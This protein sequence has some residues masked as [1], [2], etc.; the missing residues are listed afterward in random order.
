M[1]SVKSTSLLSS[2][3]PFEIELLFSCLKDQKLLTEV[4]RQLV[5]NTYTDSKALYKSVFRTDVYDDKKL[6]NTLFA[7]NKYIEQIIALR[8]IREEDTVRNFVL[9]RHCFQHNLTKEYN[10]Y[11]LKVMEQSRVAETSNLLFSYLS[12]KT[13]LDYVEEKKRQFI[14]DELIRKDQLLDA[15]YLKEKLW[16]LF[17]IDVYKNIYHFEYEPLLA[18]YISAIE[19]NK[20][21][22]AKN[23]VRFLQLLLKMMKDFDD[24][25][26]YYEALSVLEETHTHIPAKDLRLYYLA[27][28]NYA[29]KKFNTGKKEFRKEL[30]NVYTL[31]I[32]H[33]VLLNEKKTL[34]P[35]AYKNIITVA[36]QNGEFPWTKKFIDEYAAYLPKNE[37]ENAVQYNT[38]NYYYFVKNFKQCLQLLQTVQFTD[39]YYNLD[40]RCIILKIYFEEQ[41]WNLLYD[42]CFAFKAF[43]LRQ[44]YISDY[45]K[46]GYL[47]LIKWTHKLSAAV[48]DKKKLKATGERIGNDKNI[49]ELQW[50]KEQIGM[51]G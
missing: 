43:V 19:T 45:H 3:Q 39:V 38:A 7:L 15:F 49:R 29:I 2:L 24:D 51:G 18:E 47:N 41:E 13:H 50:L 44:K 17:E 36:L 12:Q 8:Y 21:H 34:E 1:I 10:G 26:H 30:F 20:M 33:G 4:T 42:H 28:I 31:Q 35:Y 32:K 48:F 16:T 25:A 27:V 14:Q 5:N 40:A 23:S 11:L 9:M 6:R 37:R 46:K 22:Y